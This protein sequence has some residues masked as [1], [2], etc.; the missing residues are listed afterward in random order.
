M[1]IHEKETKYTF[2]FATPVGTLYNACFTLNRSE[3]VRQ[4]T[5]DYRKEKKL[6]SI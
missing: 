6:W 5:C 4:S 2:F 1:F 3:T